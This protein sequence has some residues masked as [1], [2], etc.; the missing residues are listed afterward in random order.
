MYDFI[1]KL[2]DFPAFIE[3]QEYVIDCVNKIDTVE[4][5]VG[6][7]DKKAGER[8]KLRENT[9][10]E[11]TK[12]FAPFID[13]GNKKQITQEQIKDAQNKNLL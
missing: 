8:S 5:S 1:D 4:G 2:K 9:K 10:I 12:I 6:L 7:S 13:F 11:V 3:F